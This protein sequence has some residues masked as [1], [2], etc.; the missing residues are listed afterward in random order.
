MGQ[1]LYNVHFNL[2]KSKANKST[3]IYCVVYMEG[4]QYY[5]STGV[6]VLPCQW[7]KKR[8]VA[9]ISNVQSKIDNYNNKVVN[10]KLEEQKKSFTKFLEY[11]CTS[12][13]K[14]SYY[15]LRSFMHKSTNIEAA[16]LITKAYEYKYA[17]TTAHKNY[18]SRLNAFLK[19]LK[20]QRKSSLDIFTQAGFNQYVKYLKDKGATK[21]A[22]NADCQLIE[23]LISKVLSV[24]SPFLE[25]GISPVIYNKE[26]DIRP[27]KGRFALEEQEVEAI[28]K[29]KINEE[30]YFSFEDIAPKD[31]EGKV[32]PKYRSHKSGRE[33]AEYRDI[34]VLQCRCGQRVSD[35]VQFL[36][37]EVETIVEGSQ[38]FYEL[39]TKKSQKKE[40][41]FIL[42]DDYVL[43]FQKRY[44]HGF[45]VDVSKLDSNN[46]YYNLAIKKLC[47][48]AGI[49]RIITYR[50]SQ[51]V[52]CKQPVYEKITS[53]DARHTFITIMLKRGFAP[54]KLC[55]MTG[56]RDDKMIKQ[57]YSHLTS[58]DKAKALA[59]E[60]GK[61]GEPI[62]I[63][64]SHKD[65]LDRLFLRSAIT[66]LSKQEKDGLFVYR[67]VSIADI[68]A[69]INNVDN[70]D[71][72][73]NE[74][75][76][77]DNYEELKQECKDLYDMV[78]AIGRYDTD[79]EMFRR[80][81]YKLYRL[82]VIRK[83]EQLSI[84]AINKK[85]YVENFNLTEIEDAMLSV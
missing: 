55:W 22:I 19:Y 34:F 83:E 7:D 15:L 57:I 47:K 80:F 29:L 14:P 50:N 27:D 1:L 42:Q 84:E 30:D 60:M 76:A 2:R 46:S 36:N 73:V 4:R 20:E 48:L 45:T 65:V 67:D 58:N 74:V 33:L 59:E 39:K 71:E 41:A 63:V 32:N 72:L 21:S 69:T 26:K 51:D 17:G 12:E 78:W 24:E 16:E 25:Y 10:D 18:M 75:V 9:I 53:H 11:L 3:N 79:I 62:P 31:K 28:S 8:Q 40:S 44:A 43:S 35:L 81:Q 61:V 49:D 66:K 77:S 38:T 68:K 82:G 5:F 6:K 52:E 70:L 56:H 23:R 54:D 37:G 13:D 85:W 64:N